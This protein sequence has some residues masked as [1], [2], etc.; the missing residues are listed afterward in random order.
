MTQTKVFY[1][2]D[3]AVPECKQ[4]NCYKTGGSCRHTTDVYHAVN[5][6][7]KGIPVEKRVSFYESADKTIPVTE[8]STETGMKS[9]KL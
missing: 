4:R 1:L 7:Q 6:I 8:G 2:C 9:E 5:F 3:G